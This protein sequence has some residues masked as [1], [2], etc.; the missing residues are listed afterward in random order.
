MAT[1]PT[2]DELLAAWER[3]KA[4][5]DAGTAFLVLAL[6]P[7]AQALAGV[8]PKTDPHAIESAATDALLAFLKRHEKYDPAKSPVL[9]FLLLIA[10]RRLSNQFAAD[11]RHRD[12]K[13]PWDSVEFDVADRNEEE[14]DPSSFDAPELQSAIAALSE[15]DRRIIDLMRGGERRTV[16]F[17]EVMEITDHTPDEQKVAVKRAKDRILVGLKRAV[18]GKNG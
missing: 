6:R 9:K 10:R 3:L 1:P 11:R 18:G 8:F 5:P 4:D 16:A 7:L 17:A 13:I 2:D 15:T 14:D 12:G